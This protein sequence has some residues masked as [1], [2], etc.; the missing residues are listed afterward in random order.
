MLYDEI[1]E[2]YYDYIFVICK[3]LLDGDTESAKDCTQQVFLILHKKRNKLNLSDDIRCWLV[4][5]AKYEV[6]NYKKK[7]LSHKTD[8]LD[9]LNKVNIA[10]DV[11]LEA[12]YDVKEKIAALSED[13]RELIKDYYT[14]KHPEKRLGKTENALTVQI[15]RLLKKIKF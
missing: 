5:T 6:R 7:Y 4:K 1:I 10:S 12:E 3:N 11:D 15:H 13:E 2:K 8:S 14:G 9:D